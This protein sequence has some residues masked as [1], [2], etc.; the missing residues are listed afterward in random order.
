MLLSSI[1]GRW[2]GAKWLLGCLL[3]VATTRC[4]AQNLVPNGS[5]EEADSCVFG[6]G[7]L[8]SEHGA[9][10]HDWFS[11]YG[12]PDYLQ[13][14]LPYGAVNGLPLNVFTYQEPY[15]GTSCLGLFSYYQNGSDEQREWAMVELM[16]PLVQGQTYY[17]SFYAN[18]A[19]GGNAAYQTIWLASNNIGMV[20]SVEARPWEF[21]DSDPD[22]LNFAH[23]HR[24][25]ILSDTIG[26]TL[27]S[28]S[29][30]ADSAYQYLMVGNFFSNAMTDTLHF[31]PQVPPPA[32]YPR[33]Y[34]LIDKVCVSANPQGCDLV[35]K[36]FPVEDQEISLYPNPAS[37]QLLIFGAQGEEGAIRDFLG[38]IIWRDKVTSDLWLV[39]VS[40]W[41]RGP[42]VLDLEKENK[43]SSFK[44]VLVD[45]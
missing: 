5:F 28:G 22:Q 29:F 25:E 30:V 33:G 18:T 41:A 4:E 39:D 8:D 14:C 23:V 45:K 40:H 35:Q 27:V 24:L 10:P 3:F 15:E 11:A 43:H 21:L 7:F 17:A 12:T 9:G 26:W 31:A 38:R 20:F 19:F 34:T 6:L 36:I 44:F 2:P 13:T 42:Y 32:W 16:E 37:G 1:N